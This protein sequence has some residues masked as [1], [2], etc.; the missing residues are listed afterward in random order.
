MEDERDGNVFPRRRKMEVLEWNSLT[1]AVQ[2]K[3]LFLL[4]IG[5]VTSHGID[6]QD[7]LLIS[8]PTEARDAFLSVLQ[9]K[10]HRFVCVT[11][12][13][14]VRVKHLQE[15][16]FISMAPGTQAAD[17]SV[18]KNDEDL[19][20]L[21]HV[22]R[23]LGIDCRH[24][25]EKTRNVQ[26][27]LSL[28]EEEIE[29]NSL[30]YAENLRMLRLCDSLT[31]RQV[32]QLFGLTV[33]N[34][35]LN[36]LLDTRLEVSADKLEQTEGLKET[37]FF[38]LI[39]TLELNNK[40]NRIYTNKMEA[41]LEKLQSQTDSEAEKLVLSEAISSLNDYPVGERSPGYCVV[42]CVIRDREGARA[43]IEKVKHAFGKSLGYTVEVVENPNKEKIE[44]WLRLLRKPKYKYYESIVYWFMS[45]GSEEK[46]ELADG[47]RIERK[48]IIQAFSKLDNF[49][50]KPKIFFMA[51]CQG[52][53]VIHVERKISG[54]LVALDG[55]N[56]GIAP[57][58]EVTEDQQNI[59]AVY[60]QMDRLVAS[61]TLPQHYAFRLP[62]GDEM[63]PSK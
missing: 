37:L 1:S 10:H 44:E 26:K 42:F 31:V 35:V 56:E 23:H 59:T 57:Y 3:L 6:H 62:D 21:V 16:P 17:W 63:Q 38:Y 41:L 28:T 8:A 14:K 5:D 39:R 11:D 24:L 12:I 54:L 20:T 13:L 50:K 30:I 40:L 2:V 58:S 55:S 46:V 49:R 45:H 51:P 43:E 48:L 7:D 19:L 33:E 29:R 32:T 61:A 22:C 4:D 25:E 27:K 47:Y 15:Y 9:D 52:N 53:S 18:R 36:D 60:Y 34:K